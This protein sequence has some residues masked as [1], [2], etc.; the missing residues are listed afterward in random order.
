[1]VIGAGGLAALMLIPP[2]PPTTN[3]MV[4]ALGGPFAL[5]AT[6]GRTVTDETFRGKWG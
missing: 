3:S 1:M 2:V 5:T 4:G 6:D